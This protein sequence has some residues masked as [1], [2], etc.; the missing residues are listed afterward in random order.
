MS[1]YLYGITRTDHP[2]LPERTPGVGDPPCPVRAVRQGEL[3]ALVSDCPAE[4]PTERRDLLA[5]QRVLT[6]TGS[7]GVVLPLPFGTLSEDD[8]SV[9]ALLAERPEHYLEQLRGLD[10]RIE[11]N[12]KAVHREEAL[13]RQIAEQEPGVRARLEA[14]RAAGGGS[15]Q[16]RR[17]LAELTANA[18]RAREVRDAQQAE[19][20]LAPCADLHTPGGEGAGWLLNLSFLLCRDA[21]EDFVEAYRRLEKDNPRLELHIT[22][23]LPPYSFVRPAHAD[24]TPH[25]DR[26]EHGRR[27]RPGRNPGGPSGS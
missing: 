15:L 21:T 7:A 20:L 27:D 18:V 5:H 25:A 2:A 10:G 6:E 9:R 14:D 1:T 16:E 17:Q 13:L 24:R 19:R 26:R 12:V 8:E 11:Y 4:P 3:A 22:G 23:P